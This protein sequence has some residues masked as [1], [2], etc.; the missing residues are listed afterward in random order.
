MYICI[1]PLF[2]TTGSLERQFSQL[3]EQYYFERF[4]LIERQLSEVRSGRSEEFVQPQKELDKVYRTRI[5]VADV[6]RKFRLQNIE[7]KYLSEEQAA[8][9]H[10]EVSKNVLYI[11]LFND[12]HPFLDRARN[13]WPWTIFVK[14]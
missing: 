14:S 11:S 12:L 3:R 7:H 6:L 5:E 9:Q 8:S 4:N 1:S 10:F 2:P 13:K